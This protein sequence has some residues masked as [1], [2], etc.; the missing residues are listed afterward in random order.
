MATPVFRL[1]AD[2]AEGLE[3]IARDEIRE[4]LGDRMKLRPLSEKPGVLHFDYIG[5]DL[6]EVRGLR[7]IHSAYLVRRFAIPRPKALLGDEHFRALLEMV[8]TVRKMW[9]PGTFQTFRLNAAGSE[10]SVMQRIKEELAAKTGLTVAEE[11]GDLLIRLRRPPNEEAWEA[12]VRISPRPL[13][14]REWRVCNREGALNA[15]VSHA[16]VRLT[17]PKQDDV[18]LNLMCGSGTLLIERMTAG[19]AQSAVGYDHDETAL[20]CARENIEASGF[21]DTKIGRAH[22]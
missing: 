10:S 21:G 11:E 1:E 22:V 9:Q 14:T 12:L 2:V 5:R 18:F 6:R 17:E 7:T 19:T 15:T 13:A 4:R 8:E 3:E 16:M 20:T